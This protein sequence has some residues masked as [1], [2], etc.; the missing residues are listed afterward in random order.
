MR[1]QGRIRRVRERLRRI[2]HDFWIDPDGFE[3]YVG[4]LTT[5]G[6]HS[7]CGCRVGFAA[8][9]SDFDVL[10]TTFGAIRM[11]LKRMWRGYTRKFTF[12]VCRRG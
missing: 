2:W 9:A 12:S 7:A 6:I 1:R 4:R 8:P 3:A 10:T 5:G 11:D